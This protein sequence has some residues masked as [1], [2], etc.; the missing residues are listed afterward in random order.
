MHD[1]PEKANALLSFQLLTFPSFPSSLR[2]TF[3]VNDLKA[4]QY[5]YSYVYP[6][7]LRKNT[8]SPT[9]LDVYILCESGS[10]RKAEG[11]V[12]IRV[13]WSDKIRLHPPGF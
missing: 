12:R 5:V 8:Y 2:T 6:R 1:L 9:N 11:E 13:L 10:S 4:G 7:A 3:T